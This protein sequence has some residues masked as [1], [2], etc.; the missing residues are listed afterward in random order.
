MLNDIV[1]NMEQEI[2]RAMQYLIKYKN[3]NIG[4]PIFDFQSNKRYCAWETMIC[5]NKY[6][7]CTSTTVF[8][9][10]LYDKSSFFIKTWFQDIL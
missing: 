2:I 1:H 7:Y 9:L 8:K 6:L 3:K 4:F 5:V 10:F